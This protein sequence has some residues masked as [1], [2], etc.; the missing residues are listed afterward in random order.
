MPTFRLPPEW[1]PQ[2]AVLLTWPH[3]HSDWGSEGPEELARAEAVWCALAQT[4]TRFEALL[5]VAFD[6]A[7]AAHVAA[8]LDAAAVPA[9]RVKIVC[10]PS[11]DTWARDHGP[12]ILRD[13]AGATRVQDFVF[14]AWGGKFEFALDDALV[15]RLAER[16]LF[17]GAHRRHGDFVLE[18]GGIEVDDHGVLLTTEACLL[19]PNRNP[20]LDRA[21]IEAYLRRE[22]G[23]AR[24]LWLR[25]GAL[26]GDDTDSHIDTLA[27]FAP[28]GSIVYVACDDPGDA[29]FEDLRRMAEELA[30]LRD[31]QGRPYALRSLPWPAAKL[32]PREGHRMPASY[33]NY[34]VINGAVLVPTYGD[35][36]DEA[37]LRVIGAAH[38][39]REV[40]GIDCLKLIEQ[41]GSLHCVTMQLPEGSL[42]V[43]FFEQG[44]EA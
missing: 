40:I 13:G 14:N 4:I 30:G 1:A 10:A 5:V 28:D 23:V 26:A 15:A 16:G 31:A 6:G 29:H 3:A 38:P 12:I 37:A 34:L 11:D 22:L 43:D 25:H 2:A 35:A 33:A 27:R 17:A 32:H 20:E 39:G 7:H 9:D 36:A 19:N 24:V 18:G 41:G 8:Q 44:G 21:Q 42:S